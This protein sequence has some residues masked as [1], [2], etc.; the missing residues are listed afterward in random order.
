MAVLFLVS[1]AA[2]LGY[3]QVTV[4]PTK[5]AHRFDGIGAMDNGVR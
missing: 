4:D 5:L 2:V 1:S 3:Y